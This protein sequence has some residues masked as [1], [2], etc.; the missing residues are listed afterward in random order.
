MD[1]F[2]KANGADHLSCPHL[3]PSNALTLED[4]YTVLVML[5]CSLRKRGLKNSY[6]ACSVAQNEN[7]S[8]PCC[9]SV[10]LLAKA[11]GG[12]GR[13][14]ACLKRQVFASAKEAE[15]DCIPG[16]HLAK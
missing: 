3:N 6:E 10:H 7:M 8:I 5:I 1:S 2:L 13:E 4:T 9:M 11:E 15:A 14:K 12:E 16:Q